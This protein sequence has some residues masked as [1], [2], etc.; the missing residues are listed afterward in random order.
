M[1]IWS[2][3]LALCVVIGGAYL[4]IQQNLLSSDGLKNV[5]AQSNIP[6]TVRDDILT[7]KVYA[8]VQQSDMA[9][10]IDKSAV[11]RI[12]GEVANDEVLTQKMSPAFVSLEEWI[13]GNRT[14]VDFTIDIADTVTAIAGKL[15]DTAVATY[16][17]LPACTLRNTQSDAQSGTCRPATVTESAFRSAAERD[18]N[19]AIQSADTTITQDSVPYFSSITTSGES[20]PRPLVTT[21]VETLNTQL[22][23]LSGYMAIVGAISIVTGASFTVLLSRRRLQRATMQFSKK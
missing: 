16:Q 5:T 23:Q 22:L 21:T 11:E 9:A 6:A 3:L 19:Q 20:L 12:V 17:A 2:L 18:V 8:A 14:D 13:N 15:T 7:P 10:F 1:S 4:A